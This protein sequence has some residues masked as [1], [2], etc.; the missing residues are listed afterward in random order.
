MIL[1][2]SVEVLPAT[3]SS[4][5]KRWRH[6]LA[7]G[8]WADMRGDAKGLWVEGRIIALDTDYGRRILSLMKGGA[9]DGLSIGYAEEIK[10][11]PEAVLTVEGETVQTDVK[12]NAMSFDAF[13]RSC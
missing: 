2:C 1:V 9:P 7:V 11:A 10:E 13:C 5:I 12:I 4:G 8:A 3:A 6:I